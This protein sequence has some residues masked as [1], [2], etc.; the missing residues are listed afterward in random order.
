MER[1]SAQWHDMERALVAKKARLDAEAKRIANSIK[2]QKQQN[3]RL[4]NAAA[5][6]VNN[7]KNLN[8]I[9][10]NNKTI[11]ARLRRLGGRVSR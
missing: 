2:K 7:V 3:N 9:F 11:L 4:A 10:K 6:N 5:T 8:K 1:V